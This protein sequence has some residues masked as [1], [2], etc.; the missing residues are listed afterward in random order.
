MLSGLSYRKSKAGN[1]KDSEHRLELDIQQ[2]T[3]SSAGETA[4]ED[5]ER[6]QRGGSKERGGTC[7]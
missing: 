5:T 7:I 1:G 3:S 2:W 6:P 4:G